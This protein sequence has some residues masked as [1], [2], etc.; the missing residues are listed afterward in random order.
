M[1]ESYNFTGLEPERQPQRNCLPSPE[2]LCRRA[3]FQSSGCGSV[4]LERCVRDAEA[5]GS[6]PLIPTR[7]LP[8]SRCLH[9]GPFLFRAPARRRLRHMFSDPAR[10][11]PSILS[12][13]RADAGMP[14]RIRHHS[15]SRDQP[16]LCTHLPTCPDNALEK[17]W[18][19]RLCLPP[20]WP[21]MTPNASIPP[22]SSGSDPGL[23]LFP[24]RSKKTP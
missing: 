13:R 15:A 23:A 21:G 2:R 9:R 17:P 18:R 4:W 12:V 3:V 19:Q 14:I 20:P 8:G 22:G 1:A 7:H 10:P 6:N 16:R 24:F 11:I 5:G